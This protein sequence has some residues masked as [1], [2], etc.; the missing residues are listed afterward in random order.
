MKPKCIFKCCQVLTGLHGG[1]K[2][3]RDIWKVQKMVMMK[4]AVKDN[5]MQIV[6][7]ILAKESWDY[8]EMANN[9]SIEQLKDIN[10]KP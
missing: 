9:M 4:P 8:Q 10:S 2:R 3:A 5:D 6:K 1:G 7:N